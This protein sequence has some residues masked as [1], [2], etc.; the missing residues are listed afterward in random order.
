MD[1]RIDR[2]TLDKSTMEENLAIVDTWIADTA[3]KL[4]AFITLSNR[5][6]E[7]NTKE[8]GSTED[9]SAIIKELVDKELNT[10]YPVTSAKAVFMSDGKTSVDD[11]IGDL[12]DGNSHIEFRPDGSIVKTVA[13][14]NIITTTFGADGTITDKCVRPLDGGRT[15]D[16]YTKTTV[17]NDDG[18]IT[19]TLTYASEVG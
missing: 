7:E 3:D 15:E 2:P 1:I 12:Q 17:F 13:S 6:K 14:G 4:N 10:I 5:K 8:E 18:S 9:M 19:M 11:A 16:V